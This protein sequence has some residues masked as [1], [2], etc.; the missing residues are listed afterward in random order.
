M[1]LAWLLALAALLVAASV[2]TAQPDS[3]G[4]GRDTYSS[5]RRRDAGYYHASQFPSPTAHKTRS[6]SPTAPLTRSATYTASTTFFPPPPPILASP[7]S[8]PPPSAP[9]T[10]APVPSI[11]V[12]PPNVLLTWYEQPNCALPPGDYR[13]FVS[14]PRA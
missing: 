14:V 7:S 1:A 13:S 10:P 2:C 11:C 9:P 12:Q 6:V 8:T 3:Q 4:G 5:D